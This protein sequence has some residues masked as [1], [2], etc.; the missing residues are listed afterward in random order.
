L[1]SVDG[2]MPP[3]V[4][5]PVDNVGDGIVASYG[6]GAVGATEGVVS[7]R[8]TVGRAWGTVCAFVGAW[9]RFE[10]DVTHP[11]ADADVEDGVRH[12]MA[13]GRGELQ[14]GSPMGATARKAPCGFGGGGRWVVLPL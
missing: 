12:V 5:K 4:E 10:D 6:S 14:P 9:P 2:G 7:V 8:V 1:L 13:R 11:N 3:L